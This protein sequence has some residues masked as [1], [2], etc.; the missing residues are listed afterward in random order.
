MLLGDAVATRHHDEERVGG[1]SL[2]AKHG[3]LWHLLVGHAIHNLSDLRG[4]QGG[5]RRHVP[6]TPG[7]FH[8]EPRQQAQLRVSLAPLAALPC[9]CM[10][11][12]LVLAKRALYRVDEPGVALVLALVR[13]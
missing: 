1:A 13:V 6:Q 9:F 5:E 8:L 2:S 4:A 7:L 10:Q 11:A 12:L 3:P